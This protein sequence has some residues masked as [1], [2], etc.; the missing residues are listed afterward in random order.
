LP[1]NTGRLYQAEEEG[2]RRGSTEKRL[3]PELSFQ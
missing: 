3:I 2:G 1:E